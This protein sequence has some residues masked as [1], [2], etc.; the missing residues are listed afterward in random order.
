ML[1]KEL[2][3]NCCRGYPA[4]NILHISSIPIFKILHITRYIL[5]EINDNEMVEIQSVFLTFSTSYC[6]LWKDLSTSL[7]CYGCNKK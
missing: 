3:I 5:Y 6:K 2:C 4:V 7:S 1:D